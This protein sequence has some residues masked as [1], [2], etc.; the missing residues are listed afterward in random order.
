M[1]KKIFFFSFILLFSSVFS[2]DS[3]VSY[4]D[5]LLF[6][7]FNKYK[8]LYNVNCVQDKI[9]NNQGNG[10]E[11]L[12]GTRN[13]RAILHGVAY[14]GG[15][16]NYY[17]RTNKRSNKNPLPIDGLNNLLN[18]GFS[19]SVYLYVENFETAPRFLTNNNSNDTLEYFQLGGNTSSELDSI[20]MFT[21]KS[22]TNHDVGPVYLHCWNGWHQSGFVSAVLLK[23]FCGFST[24]TALHYWEDCADNWTR[25]Y[26]RI[27]NAIRDFV[28]L[29]KYSISDE[30]K[31]KICPC[32]D[33]ERANDKIMV[34]NN[35]DELKSLKITVLFP[36]NIYDLP[37][38]VSTFLDE[39]AAMLKE[40]SYLQVEVSGHT[41]SKGSI[42]HN[43]VLSEK[44]AQNV[45]D[46]LIFQGVD[47]SQLSY[48][49]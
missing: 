36:S 30:I 47:S 9:T 45:M 24:E 23:Q 42:E 49:G 10:F 35:N 32:Y 6:E 7:K 17:H 33:D 25:G 8:L 27:R 19:T 34:Q 15:G 14:R 37:P 41:D 48:K 28:P 13:F 38:S 4:T 1:F 22:I 43:L 21:Y 20:L 11:D 5:S 44:R 16:N 46:Y 26:D 18:N 12:Y 40:N 31:N 29:E 3:T 2:Q 39:Y